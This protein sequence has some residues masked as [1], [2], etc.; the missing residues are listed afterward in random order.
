MLPYPGLPT[1]I[2]AQLMALLSVVPG[3]SIITDKV[4]PDRFMHAAELVRMGARIRR[5]GPSAIVSGVPGLSGANVM[6][7]DLRAS[8]ALVLATLAAE[9]ESVIRRIYHLDRGYDRL[10]QKLNDLGAGIVRRADAPENVPPSLA[11]AGTMLPDDGDHE[12]K[13]PNWLRARDR[14]RLKIHH[15]DGIE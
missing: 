5:E 1:D 15:P 11:L 13:G 8:A 9:G 6:A 10:E 14:D 12:L 4:F 2:Q 3:I 7:S